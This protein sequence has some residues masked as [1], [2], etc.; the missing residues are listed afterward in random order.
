VVYADTNTNNAPDT[1]EG[2]PGV[3]ISLFNGTGTLLQETFTD[4]DGW[5]EFRE[6]PAGEYRLV[7]QQPAAMIDG[8]VTELNV[9]LAADDDRSDLHFREIGLRPEYVF[10]RLLAACGIAQ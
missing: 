2:V 6:L 1:T 5:Y 8:G 10:N 9:S 3:K 7:E 4:S